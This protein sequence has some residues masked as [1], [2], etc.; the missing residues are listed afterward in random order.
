MIPSVIG[1]VAASRSPSRVDL[2]A[3]VGEREQRD[4]HVA[5]PR[6]E[7]VLEPLVRRHGE[8]DA[9][10]WRIART[11]E[12]APRGTAARRAGPLEVSRD[13]G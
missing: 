13:G 11:P 10:G 1:E 6:V 8:G 4:D 5:R 7:E 2:D 12:S 3:G 9:R